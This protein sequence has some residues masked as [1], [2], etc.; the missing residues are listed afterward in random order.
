M[1][2]IEFPA[3]SVQFENLPT[4]FQVKL[5]YLMGPCVNMFI[6][7]EGLF[8]AAS[9]A[10]IHLYDAF[11]FKKE[12]SL[13]ISD[14]KIQ[15]KPLQIYREQSGLLRIVNV[16]FTGFKLLSIAIFRACEG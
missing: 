7:R 3:E 13:D 4:K 6:D 10:E 1:K 2:E 16:V 15:G 14:L 5:D 11:T 12:D 9:V 8:V